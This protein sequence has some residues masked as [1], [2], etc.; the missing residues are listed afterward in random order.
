[1]FTAILIQYELHELGYT[2]VVITGRN[3]ICLIL[4]SWSVS[5]KKNLK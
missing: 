1:M 3:Y 5:V 2:F 4:Q